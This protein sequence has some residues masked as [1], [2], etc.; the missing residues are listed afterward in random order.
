MFFKAEGV[1]APEGVGDPI[2]E[3]RANGLPGLEGVAPPTVE[4]HRGPTKPRTMPATK[5]ENTEV[6][7]RPSVEMAPVDEGPAQ[8]SA[9][10][11]GG[12]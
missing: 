3:L 2:G 9:T 6:Q 7:A 5:A 4:H 1:V 11:Q 10:E 8:V 12:H